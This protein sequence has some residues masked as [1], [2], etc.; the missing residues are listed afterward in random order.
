MYQ[1]TTPIRVRYAETDQMG[2]V[3]YGNYAQYFEVGRVET[4]RSLGMSYKAL[5]DM[6]VMLPVVEM[7]IKYLRP[8]H[9]DDVLNIQTTVK[10]LPTDHK[11]TFHQEIF[12][13]AGKLITTGTVW[14]YFLDKETRKSVLIPKE[15]QEKLSTYFQ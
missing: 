6:G 9:Y 11:I 2:I 14:L 7:N 1:F 12:N 13:E 4:I 8:A 10:E 15:L 3:Y 5:E